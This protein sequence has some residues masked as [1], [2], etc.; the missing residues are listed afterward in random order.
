MQPD[1]G[2]PRCVIVFPPDPPSGDSRRS[3]PMTSDEHVRCVRSSTSRI[4]DFLR[5]ALAPSRTAASRSVASAEGWPLADADVP[6][7][8]TDRRPRPGRQ[9]RADARTRPGGT[10]LSESWPSSLR[11]PPTFAITPGAHGDRR[12][13]SRALGPLE[14][15]RRVC[16]STATERVWT[17]RRSP[18]ITTKALLCRVTAS[19]GWR[20][21]QDGGAAAPQVAPD[22]RVGPHRWPR[23]SKIVCIGLNFRDHAAETGKD[24]PRN[25]CASSTTTA[26]V[27]AR[28]RSR[29]DPARRHEAGL[30]SRARDRDRT[31]GLRRS[32]RRAPW[33]C[34]RL[35]PPRRPLGAGVSAPSAA[36]SGSRA[37]APTRLRRSVRSWR[38]PTK[39]RI[40]RR[41]PRLTVNGRRVSGT[42]ANMI[43]P[44]STLV[45]YVSEF[46]TLLPGDV[47]STGTPAGVGHGMKP[48]PV[49]LRPGDIVELGIDG[50]GRSRQTVIATGMTLATRA[51][52][53][54]PHRRAH[55]LQRRLRPAS[56]IDLFTTVEAD[57]APR[58]P[59]DASARRHMPRR[60]TSISTRRP[61]ARPVPG[62]TMF[63]AGRGARADGLPADRRGVVHR[64]HRP[65]RRG[66]EA[67]R[68]A[69]EVAAACA[70]L[71]VSGL[72]L[73]PTAIARVASRRSAS[74]PA[75]SAG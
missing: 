56:A 75:P 49:Y 60:P 3:R 38:P 6:H 22:A 65:D 18:G 39:S 58:S 34:G 25:R 26:L 16:C 35:R 14:A 40:R 30:G 51:G 53:R 11:E 28:G 19:E 48:A 27:P 2:V 5:S 67:P 71:D 64:Q 23:P 31:A 37:R 36:A 1:D 47:I 29:A 42:T 32:T 70:L 59:A 17:P 52:P 45:S 20:T 44:V 46:M 63:A 13:N 66:A 21:G 41:W 69:L 12:M 9:H 8:D 68:P 4:P 54:Q 61:P 73:E 50:L 33:T 7:A 10:G 62:P 43:F 24:L 74:S 72:A 55:G 57:L 15:E